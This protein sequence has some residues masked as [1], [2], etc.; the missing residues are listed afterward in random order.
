MS[1][2]EEGMITCE[3]L[4][5]CIFSSFRQHAIPHVD[6]KEELK[7][8]GG[9]N[10]LRKVM[11]SIPDSIV[12]FIPK[13]IPTIHPGLPQSIRIWLHPFRRFLVHGNA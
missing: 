5:K 10:Q 1:A 4:Q 12:A 13:H 11:Q 7:L 3:V 9:T 6:N 2:Y 8:L